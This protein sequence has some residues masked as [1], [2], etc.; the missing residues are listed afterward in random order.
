MTPRQLESIN[1]L[2]SSWNNDGSI[3]VVLS[4]IK[5]MFI[6]AIDEHLAKH[7]NIEGK[8]GHA[9]NISLDPDLIIWGN[10]DE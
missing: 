3:Y 2:E 6:N 4:R 5:K 1:K 9:Y 10:E 8:P 7:Y